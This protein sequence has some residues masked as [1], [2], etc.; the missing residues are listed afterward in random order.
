MNF[1]NFKLTR[2]Q[3]SNGAHKAKVFYTHAYAGEEVIIETSGDYSQDSFDSLFGEAVIKRSFAD[4]QN[5]YYRPD[6][7]IIKPNHP[8]YEKAKRQADYWQEKLEL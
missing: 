2:R 6:Y 5:E 3:V 8:L 7:V 4:A 1:D